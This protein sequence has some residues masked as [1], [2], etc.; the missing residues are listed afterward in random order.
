MK[1]R[2]RRLWIITFVALSL[3]T[4]AGSA[5][6]FAEPELAMGTHFSALLLGS[7]LACLVALI[8]SEI[9]DWVRRLLDTTRREIL[10]AELLI[11]EPGYVQIAQDERRLDDNVAWRAAALEG[12]VRP[13]REWIDVRHP[14]EVDGLG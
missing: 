11:A 13:D 12:A 6:L 10:L 14:V 9:A 7:F 1:T 4:W 2:L 8:I 5:N 3:F